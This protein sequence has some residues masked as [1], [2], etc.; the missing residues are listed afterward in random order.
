MIL[1]C[2]EADFVLDL[3]LFSTIC[4]E[5]ITKSQLREC[6]SLWDYFH[7][8]ELDIKEINNINTSYWMDD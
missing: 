5:K 3:F 8:K 4:G 1:S 7:C 2:A 6:N